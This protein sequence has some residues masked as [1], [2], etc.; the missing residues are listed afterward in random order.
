[1]GKITDLQL[2]KTKKKVNVF[3]DGSFSFSVDKGVAIATGLRLGQDLSTSQIEELKNTDLYERCLGAV[4]RYL[5]YRPRS[6]AEVRQRL[7]YRGFRADIVDKV[8]TRLKEQRLIDDVAFAFYWKDSRLSFSPRSKRLMKREL[9]QKGI[10][11]EIADEV[12]EDLDDEAIAYDA[13]QKKTRMLATLNYDEFYR[14]LFNFLRVQ[15]FSYEVIDCVSARLWQEKQA[16][17]K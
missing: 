13:G 2:N 6:E 5:A 8:I 1:M 15:G 3:L 17:L 7:L 10:S 9:R 12:V 16:S 14:C 11:S 4:L